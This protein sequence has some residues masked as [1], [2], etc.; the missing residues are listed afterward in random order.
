MFNLRLPDYEVIVHIPYDD[1]RKK[2]K[3]DLLSVT[4]SYELDESTEYEGI[5][6]FNWAFG[7]W[8]EAVRAGDMLREFCDNPNLLVLK[9]K[10]SYKETINDIVH[11]DSISEKR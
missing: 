10:A 2:L 7:S 3:H 4:S 11:K 5:K 1:F 6:D 9:V 8:D